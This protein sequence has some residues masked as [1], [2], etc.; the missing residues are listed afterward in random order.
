MAT[1]TF[2]KFEFG[3]DV[4][5]SRSIADANKLVQA[6]NCYVSKG[7]GVRK[8]PAFTKVVTLEAGTKGL[9]AAGG[10]L[11]TFYGSGTVTHANSLFV[12]NKV[13]HPSLLATSKLHY[14]TMFNGY[15]YAAI[16]YSDG[17]IYHHYLGA[18]P[19]RITDASCPHSKSVV[20]TQKKLFAIDGDVV[21][22]CATNSPTDWSTADDAGFLPTGLQ[23]TGSDQ[24]TAVGIFNRDLM[25][26]F[27]DGAQRWVVDPDPVLH[28]LKDSI[29]TVGTSYH[30]SIA[31]VSR[32]S[33]FLTDFG[34]RSISHL[35][36]TD[37][38]ADSDVGSPIDDVVTPLITGSIDPFSAWYR[39]DG[40]Y[41]C[42]IGSTM[43]VYTYSRMEKISAWSQY[44][45]PFTPT[46]F[47]EL[48]G[49]M[50]V[51]TGD[52]VYKVDKTVFTD[53]T[54]DYETIIELPFLDF[55]KPGKLKQ[56][57]GMDIVIDGSAQIQFRYD[58]SDPTKI[59]N[60]VP[61]SGDTRSGWTVPVEIVSTAIAPVIT[62]NNSSDFAL[63]S[64]SFN[65]HLL[66]QGP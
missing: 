48:A 28:I 62:C 1:I 21:R 26:Y 23:Q 24:A 43:H 41:W 64:L 33:F 45:L 4:R 47:A 40:Q 36:N 38:M 31:P 27:E 6:K 52:D 53:Q 14:A 55:K 59:S 37:N 8:R 58:P 7:K 25:V 56:I 29:D 57:L 3:L 17:S 35:G 42:A 54:G 10:K 15:I 16:Q 46:D 51:R 11:N 34:Y 32:D 65:Y 30:K 18:S 12:A 44:T 9:F 63:H 61:V 39:G 50:Y 20:N 49:V 22:F 66:N 19:T 60:A 5:Q 2:D 13:E